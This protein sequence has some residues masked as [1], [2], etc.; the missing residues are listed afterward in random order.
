MFKAVLCYGVV[1]SCKKDLIS[2]HI[3]ANIWIGKIRQER[4]R[5]WG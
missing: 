4:K 2:N 5:V 3:N 1:S